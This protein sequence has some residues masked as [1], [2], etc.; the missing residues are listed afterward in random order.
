MLANRFAGSQRLSGGMES[1]GPSSVAASKRVPTLVA[2]SPSRGRR[3]TTNEYGAPNQDHHVGVGGR[4]SHPCRKRRV[5]IGSS[6][7]PSI[8][9]E[10]PDQMWFRETWA[11]A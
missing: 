8:Q 10:R 1:G 11:E 4:P 3:L 5:R 6:V 7:S 9:S 2:V